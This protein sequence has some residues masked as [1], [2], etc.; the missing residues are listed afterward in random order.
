MAEGLVCLFLAPLG[1]DQQ[2]TSSAL[3]PTS[4][5]VVH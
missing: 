4:D 1:P 5:L 2:F 3:T